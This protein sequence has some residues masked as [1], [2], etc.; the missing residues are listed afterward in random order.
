[1]WMPNL[2]GVK[3]II[4]ILGESNSTNTDKNTEI[5]NDVKNINII[6]FR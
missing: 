2:E 4:K 5:F 1:M 3:E 6:F